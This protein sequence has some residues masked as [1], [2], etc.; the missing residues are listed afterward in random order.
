MSDN[1]PLDIQIKIIKK[2]RGV[3]SLVRFRSVLK[4]WKYF[5]DSFEFIKGYGARHTQSH[6]HILILPSVSKYGWFISLVEDDNETFK[7]QQKEFAPFVMSPL[8]KQY[9]FSFVVGACHGLLCMYGFHDGYNQPLLVIWNPS[10]GK[11]FGIA[12]PVDFTQTV[13]GFG[14]CPVTKDPTVVKI[15]QTHNKPWHVEV[16]TLSSRVWNVI[17]SSKLPHESIILD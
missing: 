2:V 9:Y 17:P 8:V 1:I 14:V 11:S 16:F 5:I 7:V 4:P 15:I 10:I 6:S 3:K 12:A 13:Y